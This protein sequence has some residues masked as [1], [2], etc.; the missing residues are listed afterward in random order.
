[1]NEPDTLKRILDRDRVIAVVGLSTHPYRPSHS[2]A[3]Y[4][5]S[6][7]YRIVPVNPAY[8]NDTA[9]VLG[10]RCYAT[11]ADAAQALAQEGAAIEMVDVF[12]RPEQAVDVADQAIAIGA[13]SLWMQVGVV[14]D[15]AAARASAAGLDVAMNVCVKVEHERLFGATHRANA[16]SPRMPD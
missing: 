2:V 9:G 10:Q 14:S 6:H 1:M 3:A 4:M 13:K 5:Q 12:R 16:P 15:E 7:G 11:L 8:A